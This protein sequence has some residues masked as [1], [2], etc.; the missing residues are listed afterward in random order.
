MQAYHEKPFTDPALSM[1]SFSHPQAVTV[2]MQFQ[3]F[4]IVQILILLYVHKQWY[5]THTQFLT[6][7][8][9]LNNIYRLGSRVLK[10]S[11]HSFNGHRQYF[12]DQIY[13]NLF[14]ISQWIDVWLFS[15]STQQ[16]QSTINATACI[17][18]CTYASIYSKFLI[19]FYTG[20]LITLL[21]TSRN[22]SYIRNIHLSLTVI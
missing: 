12:R 16:K 13:Q 19:Y 14:G 18:F 9:S 4:S 7:F 3:R 20:L 1:P 10:Q 5:N 17:S 11:F 8:Q 21:S 22:L 6:L 15:M 2:T